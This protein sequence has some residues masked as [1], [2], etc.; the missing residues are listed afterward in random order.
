MNHLTSDWIFFSNSDQCPRG[1]EG[2]TCRCNSWYLADQDG[3]GA[4]QSS[5]ALM[6]RY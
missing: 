1:G 6:V 5:P 4:M 2:G 3:A